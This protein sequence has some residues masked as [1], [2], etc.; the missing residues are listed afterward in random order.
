MKKRI[1]IVEN[2][3]VTV[4]LIIALLGGQYEISVADNGVTGVEMAIDLQPN[5]IL[6]D[7]LLPEQDGFAVLKKIR[8]NPATQNIPVIV[9]TGWHSAKERAMAAGISAFVVKPFDVHDLER[10]IIHTL[11]EGE[12]Q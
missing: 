7:L 11:E 1:L 9:V 10:L 4:E 5:L 8:S 12:K 6:L 2:D 3:A